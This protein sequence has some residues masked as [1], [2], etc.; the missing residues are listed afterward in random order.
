M[1]FFCQFL[2]SPLSTFADLYT[3][4]TPVWLLFQSD[5]VA[6]HTW[7]G[8]VM[9]A[10][11]CLDSHAFPSV[12]LCFLSCFLFLCHPLSGFKSLSWKSAFCNNLLWKYVKVMTL[13]K[14]LIVV[15]SFCSTCALGLLQP[16]QEHLCKKIWKLTRYNYK[17][18]CSIKECLQRE[19]WLK[20]ID[21]HYHKYFPL[22]CLALHDTAFSE[23]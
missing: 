10:T 5:P 8:A 12:L 4:G 11:L 9:P 13:L 2:E 20:L 21:I 17:Y 23:F 1:L 19:M 7:C 18:V 14:T 3:L 15:K 16:I 22:F 6:D